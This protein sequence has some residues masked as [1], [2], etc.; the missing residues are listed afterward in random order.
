MAP[1]LLPVV[2]RLLEDEDDD[3]LAAIMGDDTLPPEGEFISPWKKIDG[4]MDGWNYGAAWYD[5]SKKELWHFDGMDQLEYDGPNR[6]VQPEDID[7]PGKLMGALDEKYPMDYVDAEGDQD[8]TDQVREEFQRE[9]ERITELYKLERARQKNFKKQRTWYTLDVTP[10]SPHDFGSLEAVAREMGCD[11]GELKEKPVELQWSL[12]ASS[13]GW[14]R[15]ASR[16]TMSKEEA[17]E[18]G[19]KFIGWS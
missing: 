8:L 18:A 4:D 2:L 6:D 7:L 16:F 19:I 10:L 12:L 3:T 17:I 11:F 1:K 14:D 5:E 13:H 15:Y 9:R